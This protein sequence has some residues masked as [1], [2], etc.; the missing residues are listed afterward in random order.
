MESKKDIFKALIREFRSSDVPKVIPREQELPDWCLEAAPAGSPAPSSMAV[1]ITGPRRSGKTYRLFQIMEQLCRRPVAPLPPHRI[2]Y[3]NF[4]D[5]RLLPMKGADLDLLLD[6]F[7]ELDPENAE[8]DVALFLDEIHHVEDWDKFVRRLLE[9]PLVRVFLTGS[10]ARLR[11]GLLMVPPRCRAFSLELMPLSFREYLAFKGV[12]TKGES[13]V[14]AL[15]YKVRFL[16]DEYLIYGGFPEVALSELS[17]KLKVLRDYFDLVVYKD[18]VEGFGIRNVALLKDLIKHLVSNVGSAVSLNAFY[19]GLLPSHRV[20]RDTV[21]EYV[22]YLERMDLVR[23]IPIFSPSDKAQLVNPKRVFTLDNG[24]RNA[25]SF[26]LAEDEERL[27]KNLVFQALN[28]PGR[29][30]FY[31]KD[32]GSV[33]FVTGEDKKLLGINVAY[34]SEPDP[35]GMNALMNLGRAAS[36]RRANLS[37]ITKD[38]EK[39]EMGIRFIPL[40]KWLLAD[41]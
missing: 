14:P 23:L 39:T 32:G 24:L 15:K 22:S 34:G 2:L 3:I 36:R 4:E 13:D 41:S 8:Q 17:A 30:I 35:A 1:S 26:R 10:S 25:V 5:D 20:S 12:S 18:M 33:D 28:K 16:L 31:W 38:T 21:L 37:V 11:S 40:W 6:A 9:E 7:Y 29:Q 27:A 19:Q